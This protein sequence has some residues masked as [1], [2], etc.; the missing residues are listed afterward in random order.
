MASIIVLSTLVSAA[1]AP[2]VAAWELVASFRSP[3]GNPYGY[4]AD[5][6]QSGWI[7]SDGSVP[8]VNRVH[9]GTGSI[10]SSFPAPGGAGAWG[11]ANNLGFGLFISNNRTSWIYKTTTNGSL[12]SSFPCPV[13]GPADLDVEEGYGY[14]YIAIPAR[15]I[16]AVVNPTT[17]S[18]VSTFAAPGSRPTGCCGYGVTLIADSA[19]HTIYEDGRPVIT[20]IQTPMGIDD[21]HTLGQDI[22]YFMWVVDAATGYI[23]SY[24]NWV[25]TEPASLGRVKAL[26]R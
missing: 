17:G 3:I 26:F 1:F 4:A 25:G 8:Y 7:N 14:L 13:L 16:I 18:L 6:M 11:V 24:E 20:G 2:A 19:T 5:S 9:L 22:G 10:V 15:N 23:Y 21:G 12:Y